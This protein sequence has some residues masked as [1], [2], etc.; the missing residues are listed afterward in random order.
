MYFVERFVK[1]MFHKAF[2]LRTVPVGIGNDNIPLT[3]IEKFEVEI[4]DLI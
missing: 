2:L 1:N 3:D 4:R